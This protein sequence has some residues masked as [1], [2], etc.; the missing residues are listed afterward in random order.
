M[1]T[2]IYIITGGFGLIVGSFLNAVIYRLYL[3]ESAFRGRSHCP[4]CNKTLKWYELVPVFSFIVQ[5]GRCRSCAHVI[6]WQYPLVELAT[7]GLFIFL[8]SNSQFQ[9]FNEFL[10]AQTFKLLFMAFIGSGLIVIFAYDLKHYI[11]PDR[12][13]IPLISATLLAEIFGIWDLNFIWNFE[14]GI[15]HFGNVFNGLALGVLSALP[16]AAI[17]FISKGRAMGFGDVK[18]SF[19]MGI[20]LGYP[21]VIVAMFIAFVLG[22]IIGIGLMVAGKKSLQSKVPFGPFL[23]LGVFLAL[24]WSEELIVF[25]FNLL[26]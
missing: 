7:G 26:L 5:R 11:I 1:Q 15:F 6:S 2:L 13:L 19:F 3:S 21:A 18:L 24:F 20:L 16:F 4:Y 23:I 10:P 14:L 12:V 17:H 8:I 25:Y 9:I 22:A